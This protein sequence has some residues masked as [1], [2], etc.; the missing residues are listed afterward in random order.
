MIKEH[1]NIL[2]YN[3]RDFNWSDLH[4]LVEIFKSSEYSMPDFLS[5]VQSAQYQRLLKAR[6]RYENLIDRMKRC[7][8]KKSLRYLIMPDYDRRIFVAV[9]QNSSVIGACS[10]STVFGDFWNIDQLAVDER[11]RTKGVGSSLIN[12]AIAFIRDK[13]GSKISTSV[14]S[15]NIIAKKLYLNL[16]FKTKH[17]V[18][19][20]VLDIKK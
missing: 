16:N 4:R 6:H 12:T 3:I 18:D 2:E 5:E 10:I 8:F 19:Y 1:K 20:M 11:F 14:G 17:Q 7:F 13:G 9:D 15:N